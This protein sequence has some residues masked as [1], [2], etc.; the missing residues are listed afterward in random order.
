MQYKGG[1]TCKCKLLVT[2]TYDEIAYFTIYTLKQA[3]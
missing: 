3:V 2:I 1:I